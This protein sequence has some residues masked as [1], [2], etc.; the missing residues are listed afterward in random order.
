MLYVQ[1]KD[2]TLFRGNWGFGISVIPYIYSVS[3]LSLKNIVIAIIVIISTFFLCI[4]TTDKGRQIYISSSGFQIP[5]FLL[6][7]C[8]LCTFEKIKYC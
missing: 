7:N 8:I 1:L 4:A 5:V 3:K 6:Y 2:T